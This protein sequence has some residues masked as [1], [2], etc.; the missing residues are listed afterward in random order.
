MLMDNFAF[1]HVCNV[2]VQC[3]MYIHGDTEYAFATIGHNSC[4][5]GRGGEADILA[6]KHAGPPQISME[7]VASQVA[8]LTTDLSHIY[9]PSM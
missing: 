1:I 7:Q 2:I 9:C 5:K 8:Y 4:G 3:R 6:R